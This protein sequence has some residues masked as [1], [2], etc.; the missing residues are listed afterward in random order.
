[1][2]S[3]IVALLHRSPGKERTI[4]KRPESFVPDVPFGAEMKRPSGSGQLY[5]KGGNSYGP[6]HAQRPDRCGRD[7]GV[8]FA[9]DIVAIEGAPIVWEGSVSNWLPVCDRVLELD[10][11]VIVAGRGPVTDPS[12]VR[13]R[14]VVD[15][16]APKGRRAFGCT[17]R[18]P[19]ASDLDLDDARGE[20]AEVVGQGAVGEVGSLRT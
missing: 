15:R 16:D 9:G 5:E 3:A 10:A 8:V 19:V 7:A 11:R 12:G 2:A 4:L 14:V 20:Q 17:R 18:T 13:D 1:L 6:A